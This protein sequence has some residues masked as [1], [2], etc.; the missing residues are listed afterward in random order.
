LTRFA[1][2]TFSFFG[3]II[4]RN[5]QNFRSQCAAQNSRTENCAGAKY[6][7]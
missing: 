3:V 6:V 2:A 4:I 1:M 7:V 5:A